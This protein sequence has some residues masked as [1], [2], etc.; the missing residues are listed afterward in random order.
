MP[1]DTRRITDDSQDREDSASAV[2]L[3]E[4]LRV[5]VPG[6][7][8][9]SSHTTSRPMRILHVAHAMYPAYGGPAKHTH[10][11]CRALARTGADVTL[12]ATNLG[13]IGSWLP[14]KLPS[15]LDVPLDEM[16]PDSGVGVKYFPVQWPYRFATSMT[17]ARALRSTIPS[18]DIV[19]I[20]SLYRFPG[21]AAGHYSQRFGIPYI[22]TPHGSLS[23]YHLGRRRDR[24]QLYQRLVQ[25]KFLNRASAIQFTTQDEL[26][27]AKPIGIQAPGF[28]V[29]AAVNVD[30]YSRLPRPGA[31]TDAY[32]RTRGKQLVSFTG[33]LAPQKGLD[34]LISAF[35][36]V[37]ERHPTAHL[38][39]AGPDEENYE[40]LV[41]KWLFECGVAE[42]VTLTGLLQG[43]QLLSLLASTEVWVMPSR[44]ESFGLAVVEAM[45]SGLPIV[46][47]DKVGIHNEVLEAK[48]GLVVPLDVG[49]IAGA[50]SALL[51]DEKLRLRLG[52][53]GRRLVA[54]RYTWDNAAAAMSSHYE[55]AMRGLIRR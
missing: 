16:V 13:E 51:D 30:E 4:G 38:V 22:V 34:L 5:A 3:L 24:K 39:L 20:H 28:V 52:A 43:D 1:T 48:A 32:P 18:V 53:A 21:L 35:A 2:P 41:R 15:L 45:A 23:P 17:M 46:I 10:E 26:E 9:Q 14:W 36:I 37:R 47:S 50:I 8:T 7:S 33:R 12:F 11:L 6:A 29:P 19:H 49:R 44:Y 54:S 31:F 42:C 55:A 25:Q 40:R 27:L